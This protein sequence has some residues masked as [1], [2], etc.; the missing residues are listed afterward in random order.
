MEKVSVVWIEDETSHNVPLSQSLI[1]IKAP[2][3]FNSMK[4]EGGEVA[5]KEKYEA[6][7]GWFMRFKE[8]C[9]LHNIEMQG[10]AA[11]ADIEAASSYPEDL[12][13]IMNEGGYAKQ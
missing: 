10:E 4:A 1:Q 11:S 12:A 2:T 13:T 7:R 6:S 5:A 3:L 9:P 8:W